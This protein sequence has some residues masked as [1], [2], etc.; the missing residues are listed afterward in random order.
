MAD[1]RVTT[2]NVKTKV[3]ETDIRPQT[4]EEIQHQIEAQAQQVVEETRETNRLILE[5]RASN[6]INNNKDF[7]ALSAPTNAQALKQIQALTRQT[8]AIIRLL[9]RELDDID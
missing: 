4:E 2:Y 8:N 1:I 9:V 6:A 3:K 7:L 5:D